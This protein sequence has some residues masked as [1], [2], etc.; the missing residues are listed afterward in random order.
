MYSFEIVSHDIRTRCYKN[1]FRDIEFIGADSQTQLD[2]LISL[3]NLLFTQYGS[4]AKKWV[5]N[6]I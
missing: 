4:Q 3:P 6:R 1:R 5:Q 2:D